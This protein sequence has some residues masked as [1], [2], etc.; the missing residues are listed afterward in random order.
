MRHGHLPVLIARIDRVQ[1]RRLGLAIVLDKGPAGPA[2]L[3]VLMAVLLLLLLLVVL[4]R[5]LL[6]FPRPPSVRAGIVLGI[7][8]HRL[9]GSDVHDL[10]K[11]HDRAAA[12]FARRNAPAVQIKTG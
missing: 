1:K 11:G 4:L 7:R 2:A 8:R 3:L 10:A 9:V 6:L 5:V 12:L